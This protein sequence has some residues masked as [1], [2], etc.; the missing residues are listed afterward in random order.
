[1]AAM[2]WTAATGSALQ[3]EQ[4][5]RFRA[6]VRAVLVDVLVLDEQGNPVSSL[7][8]DDFVV[9]EDKVQ[10]DIQSFDVIDW[11]SY[12][13][14]TAPRRL[15]PEERAARESINTFPRRFIFVVNRQGAEFSFLV[16]AR[17]ALESFVVE[18]MAD[19]D[20]AM[21]IDIGQ[22][23][24]ITQQFTPSKQETLRAL[25][26]IY[27][28]RADIFFGT[29]I[30]TRNVYDTLESIGEG[31]TAVQGR[32]IVLFMS[33]RLSQVHELIYDLERTIDSLNQS[34]TTVYAINIE[35][36]LA[37]PGADEGNPIPAELRGVVGDADLGSVDGI[38]SS[39]DSFEVGGLF[40]LAYET[41]G[42]YFFNMNVFE[43]AMTSIGNENKRYYLL[44]YT[45]KNSELDGEY[46]RI[47]VR[48]NRPDV[49]VRAR[50]GYFANEEKRAVVA[51]A[52]RPPDRPVPESP[53]RRAPTSP[54]A[55]LPPPQVEITNYLFPLEPGKVDVPVAVAFPRELLT[56]NQGTSTKRN[57]TLILSDAGKEISRF[58]QT[59]DVRNFSVVHNF[60][61]K[62]GSYL[63]Q[64]SL[65]DS[66]EVIYQSSSQLDVPSKLDERFGLS[67]IAP[68]LPPKEGGEQ[69]PPIRPTSTLERGE[70]VYLHF[71]VFAGKRGGPSKSA[72]VTYSILHDGEELQRLK[73][74]NPIDLTKSYENGFP[75]VTR[76]PMRELAPGDY[77]IRV[78]IEDPRLGRRATSEIALSIR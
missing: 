19:G 62:P 6:E 39:F 7:N 54:I 69:G 45:P 51:E 5:P 8:R 22:S 17:R 55:P 11:T 78:L 66:G 43:P 20:E 50:K 37:G 57:A 76:L 2:V 21:I 27:P 75:M 16:R 70:D 24:R 15:E 49:T 63:L 48:V 53:K 14:D 52:E 23:T 28:M 67:S 44:T 26:R 35:G 77:R 73:Q 3:K 1:M 12:V 59:V 30:S 71:R 64:I 58:N 61:L 47:E 25:K 4:P 31:L 42:R 10:Q 60:D 65:D 36:T 34:N 9:F 68:I 13:A 41:G 46:R 38:T 33:P 18:S 32:K 56:S 74:P 72:Q 29:Q 40:P